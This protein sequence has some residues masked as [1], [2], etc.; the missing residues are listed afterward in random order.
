MGTPGGGRLRFH[1]ELLDAQLL[2]TI[3]AAPYGGADIGECL[4]VADRIGVKRV[5]LD[6]WYDEW[7]TL[8]DRVA[9]LAN[10]EL[11][12]GRTTSAR[13]AFFRAS[14]YYR[15]AGVM[16]LGPGP[17][18]RAREA[19]LRQSE[20]FRA[21]AAL[22]PHP[23]EILGIPFDGATL[24]GYFFAAS[25]D[26]EKGPAVVLIG[27]YDSTCE[28]LYF[29]NGAAAVERGYHVFAFDGPGQG[30]ALLQQGL[31]LSRGFDRSVRAVVDHLLE[32]A[33]VDADRI[34]LHGLSL[35]AHLA[36]RAASVDH[37]VAACIADCGSYDLFGS[38]LERMPAPLARRFASGS[39]AARMIAGGAMRRVARQ[40]TAGWA[41]RRGQL[42]HGFD[43]PIDYVCSLR[44]FTLEGNA[45]NIACPLLVCYAEDD[46]ISSSAPRLAAEAPNATLMQ[47]TRAEGAGDHCEA[48][49][50][51]LFHARVF[52]WLDRVLA[53]ATV[54]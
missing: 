50:R 9:A 39:R 30:G 53:G 21:G 10:A 35:G 48:G 32:R 25:A 6:R 44:E 47:F 1:D 34:V 20:M 8:A 13:A 54:S 43:K 23:P 41:L 19:N 45:A 28:E 18:R 4:A 3:G 37:R 31:T 14:S 27:G 42:V 16:L 26:G 40:P 38:A 49:A 7:S 46:E 36:P 29:L 12:D 17:D 22:L 33:E 2:R 52:A 24:P 15:T 11:S 51:L 5:D